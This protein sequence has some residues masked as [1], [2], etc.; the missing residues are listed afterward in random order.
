MKTGIQVISINLST[1]ALLG[2]AL[3]K[4]TEL[5]YSVSGAQLHIK[6]CATQ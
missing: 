4:P 5:E 6:I 2:T 1:E 3:V